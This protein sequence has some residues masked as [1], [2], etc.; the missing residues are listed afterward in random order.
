MTYA[1]TMYVDSAGRTYGASQT[2]Q[3]YTSAT[4]RTVNGR[5]VV[6]A[7]SW[8]GCQMRYNPYRRAVAGAAKEAASLES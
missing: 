3:A 6:S 2:D 7:G 1:A 4:K 5:P 8:F